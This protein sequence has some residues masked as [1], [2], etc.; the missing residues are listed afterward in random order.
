MFEDAG[1]R[2]VLLS[3]YHTNIVTPEWE[4]KEKPCGS[5]S[6]NISR[7]NRLKSKYNS[8]F[9]H[10][11]ANRL[12]LI[13]RRGSTRKAFVMDFQISRLPS[14]LLQWSPLT[15]HKFSSVNIQLLIFF[16]FFLHKTCLRCPTTCTGELDFLSVGVW[17]VNVF[18]RSSSPSDTRSGR[19][20]RDIL[21]E[22][23]TSSVV[24]HRCS[25]SC[26][27][28]DKLPLCAYIWIWPESTLAYTWRSV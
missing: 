17:L 23:L 9:R 28:L 14:S 21:S 12:R 16:L 4:D 20:S 26:F 19:K 2:G 1:L 10:E 13:Q 8:R 5:H 15:K 22:T 25:Q 11:T 3:V 7:A 27:E 18:T 6:E 24:A